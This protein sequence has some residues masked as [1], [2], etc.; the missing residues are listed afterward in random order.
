MATLGARLFLISGLLAATAAPHVSGIHSSTST[1]PPSAISGQCPNQPAG[2]LEYDPL[3]KCPLP[4]VLGIIPDIEPSP[5]TPW[6]LTPKCVG[7]EQK[8]SNTTSRV[9]CIFTD[10]NFRTGHGT[11]LITTTTVA[12]HLVGLEAFNDRPARLEAAKRD[13]VPAYEIV[14]LE[15]RGKGAVATRDIRRGEIIMVDVPALLVGTEFLHDVRAHHRRRL[16]KQAINRLPGKTRDEVWSL[17]RNNGEYEIDA[18]MGANA[19]SVA[20]SDNGIHVGIFPKVSRI[21]HSCRP[22]AY[23]RF[24]ETRLTMEVVSYHTIEKGEEITMSYVPLETKRQERRKYL[25][26]NWGIDCQCSL[27]KASDYDQNESEASRGRINELRDSILNARNNGFFQDA[28]NIAED[29][30]LVSEWE[31]VPP[32]APEYHDILAELYWRKGELV[33]A[34][35]FGRMALDEWVKFGSV[36]DDQLEH[37]RVFLNQ[38]W[39]VAEKRRKGE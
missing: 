21:N 25:Q 33:N 39:P 35:R 30:H 38:V 26:D 1:S 37:A 23:Y 14:E 34:T 9:H 5:E 6:T 7:E 4:G 22:N 28:I 12:A 36:D 19:N 15:G 17:S 3:R 20:I 27:C 31:R 11:S 32:L 29:W 18:I 8:I 2:R 24:S 13:A 10:G 16:I